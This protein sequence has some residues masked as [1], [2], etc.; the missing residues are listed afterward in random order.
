MTLKGFC[1]T[2]IQAGQ[3]ESIAHAL[4]PVMWVISIFMIHIWAG[5]EQLYNRRVVGVVKSHNPIANAT[6]RHTSDARTPPGPKGFNPFPGAFVCVCMCK[7]NSGHVINFM[8][9]TF[10]DFPVTNKILTSTREKKYTTRTQIPVSIKCV[11]AV[12]IHM[13]YVCVCDMASIA[14]RDILHIFA[15]I[16]ICICVAMN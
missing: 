4:A 8:S 3:I 9:V 2:A 13:P 1:R 7:R 10:Y 6:S 16:R 11:A 14:I 12:D 5:R 15:Y